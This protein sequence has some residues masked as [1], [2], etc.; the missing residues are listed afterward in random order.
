MRSSTW[1]NNQENHDCETCSS[2]KYD[3]WDIFIRN[4]IKKKAMNNNKNFSE[5]KKNNYLVNE[6]KVLSIKLDILK[7]L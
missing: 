7:C 2:K 4:E 6:K 3:W 1:R 5:V